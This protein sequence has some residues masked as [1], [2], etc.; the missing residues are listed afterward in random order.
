MPNILK[1]LIS[2]F[3]PFHFSSGVTCM[4]Y[5]A[6]TLFKIKLAQQMDSAQKKLCN[7]L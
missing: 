2:G 3:L 5:F 7:P 1:L 4:T 6:V